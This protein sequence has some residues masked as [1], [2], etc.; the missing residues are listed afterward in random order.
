MNS[1]EMAT[2]PTAPAHSSAWQQS[3][4]PAQN[5]DVAGLE[6]ATADCAI[7]VVTY[8]S[9]RDITALLDSIPD[10][11]DGLDVR[12]IV[13]DNGSTDGTVDLVRNASEVVCIE[14]GANL[15]YAGAI[16]IGRMHARPYAG[17]LILNP[18]LVLAP[19]SIRR[20]YDALEP[21]VGVTVPQL[22]DGRG[23]L[24]WSLRREPS[25]L[26]ALGDAMFGDHFP[27]RPHWLSEMIRTEDIYRTR[28][29]VD[30]ATGAALLIAA[31]CDTVVGPWDDQTF[32]LYSE[33]TDF[34]ARARER[35]YRI[36][37]IPEAQ[38]RHRGGGSGS[39][40]TLTALMAVNRIR[41]YRKR[42]P[43]HVAAVFR[44]IVVLHELV[45]AYDRAHRT[46]LHAVTSQ[47]SWSSLPGGRP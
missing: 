17:L 46:A 4:V 42:H 43:R 29:V 11:A 3:A 45:R 21:G 6:K 35:G 38:V 28:R 31:E 14:T 41:Y 34:F 25:I 16:N 40:P 15:G 33:E 2:A 23:D 44:A 26:R 30:W 13:V 39:A 36:D 12:T 32:F 27:D 5:A 1:S 8:N 9:V 24:Y 20:L 47:S 7:V 18:D 19:G 22:L 37:Y 10:A